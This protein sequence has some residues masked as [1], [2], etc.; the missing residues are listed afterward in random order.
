MKCLYLK[1]GVKEPAHLV[2]ARGLSMWP[3]LQIPQ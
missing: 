1:S 2:I 3:Y